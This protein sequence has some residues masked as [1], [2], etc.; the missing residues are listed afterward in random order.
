VRVMRCMAC[1]AEMILLNVVQDDTMAVP[2]FE[3]HT[4][5]C[6]ECHDV[7]RRFFIHQT[8]PRRQQPIPEQ[9]AP[10]VVPALTVHE[11]HIAAPDLLIRPIDLAEN[12]SVEPTQTD[13]VEPTIQNRDHKPL[14]DDVELFL[15]CYLL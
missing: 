1:G 2:G 14:N 9:A 5:I 7:E 4:F 11:E 8:R 3:H 15:H 12:V 10:S 6:S 13:P